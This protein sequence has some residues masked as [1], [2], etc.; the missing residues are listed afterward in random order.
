MS[1]TGKLLGFA[2]LGDEDDYDYEDD[3]Y[4]DDEEEDEQEDQEQRGGLF[5][6]LFKKNNT[7]DDEYDDYEESD[8]HLA[9][10][11]RVDKK[12]VPVRGRRGNM[13][14]CIIKPSSIEDGM[15]IS[16]TLVSGRVVVLNL[17]GIQVETAQRIIDFT[18]GACYSIKGKMQKISNFFFIAT[19]DD[20]DISGDVQ[21]ILNNNANLSDY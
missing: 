8:N 7:V 13:E 5:G 3:D 20:V 19:P 9:S 14:V 18:S 12:I 16:N 10:K 1:L 21:D 6:G 4:M 2:K 11:K 17:E 15:E